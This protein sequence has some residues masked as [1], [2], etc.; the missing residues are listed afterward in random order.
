MNSSSDDWFVIKDVE[1]FVQHTRAFVFNSYGKKQDETKDT[2]QDKLMNLSPMDEKEL[3]EVLSY[4]ES[5]TIVKSFVKKEKN[6]KTKEIRFIIND[7]L[8]LEIMES[9]GDRMTSN[10]L[11]G[12][13]KKGLIETGFDNESNDFV[14]WIKNENQEKPETN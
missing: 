10:I 9:L 11:Q 3:E 8:Y 4:D 6:K 13:V 1:S 14:F 5:L 12:L 7:D 2:D